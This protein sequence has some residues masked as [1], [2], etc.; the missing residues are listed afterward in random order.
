MGVN[1]LR[2]NFRKR[3]TLQGVLADEIAVY[4]LRQSSESGQNIKDHGP[5]SWEG[6][7]STALVSY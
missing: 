3:K 7:G 5:R 1:Y 2:K 6:G 4:F